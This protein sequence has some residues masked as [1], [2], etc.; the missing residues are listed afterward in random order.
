MSLLYIW[1]FN[2]ANRR[3]EKESE[4]IC[5]FDKLD[6]YLTDLHKDEEQV[7]FLEQRVL[8]FRKSSNSISK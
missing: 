5:D 6:S 1:N 8:K 4:I 7:I 2:L 3:F